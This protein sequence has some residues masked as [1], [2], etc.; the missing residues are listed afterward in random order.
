MPDRLRPR[1]VS[2]DDP[3]AGF[4]NRVEQSGYIVEVDTDPVCFV[5]DVELVVADE[6][7]YEDRRILGEA[8]VGTVVETDV[9]RRLEGPDGVLAPEDAGLSDLFRVALPYV[10]VGLGVDP[11]QVQALLVEDLGEEGVVAVTDLPHQPVGLCVPDKPHICRVVFFAGVEGHPD[12][13]ALAADRRDEDFPGVVAHAL[14]FLYPAYGH[15]LEGLDLHDI[16]MQTL[17]DELGTVDGFDAVLGDGETMVEAQGRDPRLQKPVNRIGDGGLVFTGAEDELRAAEGPQDESVGKLP[18][19]GPAAAAVID[20]VPV[21]LQQGN[22]GLYQ[23][24]VDL[25]LLRCLCH[26]V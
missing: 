6:A 16:V 8:P 25:N 17:E 9:R 21:R 1:V 18:G 20:L 2:P 15:A 13:G 12:L 19:L 10:L 22:E 11:F 26:S 3:L 4:R 5:V 14:G 23:V 24:N 7:A